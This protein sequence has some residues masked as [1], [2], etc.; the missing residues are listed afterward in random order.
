MLNTR[1]SNRRHIGLIATDTI[2]S[3]LIRISESVL[4]A[5]SATE[6][7]VTDDYEAVEK[8]TRE[9]TY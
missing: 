9:T 2:I 3:V 5:S 6:T 7:I 8:R 1:S 4:A